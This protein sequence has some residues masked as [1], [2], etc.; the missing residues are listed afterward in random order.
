VSIEG[1]YSV[2]R[3]RRHASFL[4]VKVPTWICP[5]IHEVL[6][7]APIHRCGNRQCKVES[8]DVRNS[9]RF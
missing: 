2:Y 8:D 4:L 9:R 1:F 6:R 7:T 5:S 3:G